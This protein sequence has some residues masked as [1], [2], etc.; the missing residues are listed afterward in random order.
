M[1]HYNSLRRPF[2]LGIVYVLGVAACGGNDAG[3]GGVTQPPPPD[4]SSRTIEALPSETFAPAT[5]TV[6]AGDTV[7]FSFGSL[8]HNV[9]FDHVAGAPPD[10]PAATSNARVTRLFSRAGE[11]VYHCHIHPAMHGTV[12]VTAAPTAGSPGYARTRDS[13]VTARF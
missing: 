7:V 4:S 9:F 5:L 2:P 8:A 13:L 12:I 6:A 3:Y 10:I 1:R 11:F